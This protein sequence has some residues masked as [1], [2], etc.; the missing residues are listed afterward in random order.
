MGKSG[1]IVYKRNINY[2]NNERCVWIIYPFPKSI[3]RISQVASG[4]ESTYDHLVVTEV[5]NST[6]ANYE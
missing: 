4:M 2:L 1:S 6:I 5:D 3:V